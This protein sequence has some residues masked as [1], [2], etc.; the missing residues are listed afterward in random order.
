MI[1]IDPPKPP[2]SRIGP[3]NQKT[4]GSNQLFGINFGKVEVKM[5]HAGSKSKLGTS[6]R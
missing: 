3:T 4:V 2:N 1:F 5:E 6:D